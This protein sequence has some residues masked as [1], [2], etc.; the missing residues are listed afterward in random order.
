MVRSSQDAKLVIVVAHGGRA[1]G[2]GTAHRGRLTYLR[3]LPFSRMWNDD[4]YRD[5]A[6]WRLRYRYRGWNGDAAD[7]MHDVAWAAAEAQRRHP[8]ATV[9]LLGHSMGGRAALLAAGEA[10]VSGVCAL[11]PWIERSDPIEQLRG[12]RVLIAHGDRDRMTS[13]TAAARYAE[14]ARQSGIDVAMVRVTG[15]GH[16]MLRRREVWNDLVKRFVSRM[17]AEARSLPR[18]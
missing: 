15:A 11:A 17:L 16:A 9:L 10:N 4:C 18:Q 5:L 1:W 14:R 13:P 7:A 12:R 6:V 2:N 8:H 3:M